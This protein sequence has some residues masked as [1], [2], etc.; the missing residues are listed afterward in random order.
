MGRA[1][2]RL[3]GP[4]G[5]AA[6]RARGG[7]FKVMGRASLLRSSPASCRAHRCK[8]GSYAT[9]M[10]GLLPRK[11]LAA[12]EGGFLEEVVAGPGFGGKS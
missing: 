5:E 12:S 11:G 6:T 9:P 1:A 8:T 10:A 3:S 7:L 2:N 4:S